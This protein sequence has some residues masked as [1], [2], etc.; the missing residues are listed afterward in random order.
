MNQQSDYDVPNKTWRECCEAACEYLNPCG[1]V[2]ATTGRTIET[3]NMEF[4]MINK[5]LHPNPIVRSGKCPQPS[6]FEHFPESKDAI[7]RFANGNLADLTT[8]LLRDFIITKLLPGLLKS[9]AIHDER[10]ELLDFYKSKPP[11]TTTVWRWM[12]RLGYKYCA[13]KKSFYVDGHERA[14]QRF[15]RKEFTEEYLLRL[16]PYCHRWL[17]VSKDELDL[18]I[19]DLDINFDP[20]Y[21]VCGYH[22]ENENGEDYVEFHVDTNDFVH[23]EASR[24]YVFGG[25]TSIRV[26]DEEFRPIIIFGQD[27]SAFHQFLL[28]SKNWT[29]PKGECALLPKSEGM[30]VMVSAIISRDTGFGLQLDSTKLAEI[31]YSRQGKKY[32]DEVAALDVRNCIDKKE[33]EESPFV[34]YFELGANNEGYWGYNHMVLQLE[35]CVDCLKVVYP[36]LDFVFLF[37]HSSGHSKKRRGGLDAGQMNSGFGGGQPTMRKSRIEHIDGYLGPYDSI[38]SAG[39]EQIMSFFPTDIGPFWMTATEQNVRRLDRARSDGV[40][41][42]PRNK[43]KKDLAAELSVPGLVL[44]PSKFRLEKLQEMAS[45][46]NIPL[47]K[48]I[49][50]IEAGWVGKQKGLLQVLWE[51]GWID[52]SRLDDYA[53]MKKDETGAVDEEFSLHCLMESCLDFANET[54]ELQSM[55]E[56]M[57]VRVISTT[58][59]HAEMAGEGIEYLWGVA[60]SWYRSKPLH[61]KS[62]KASFLELVRGC[63]DPNLITKEKVRSFSKRA[64]SYICAYYAFEHTKQNNNDNNETINHDAITLVACEIKYKTQCSVLTVVLLT[65][66]GNS[67]MPM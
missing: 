2:A 49:P 58:K 20:Q 45:A 4:R 56:K 11:S 62:K 32:T 57:G 36:H 7:K 42:K 30:A 37:D 27:E 35:D 66:I 19:D 55:G 46:Q 22:Y 6:L 9:I 51:R 1:N 60:K 41:P 29:G 13:R 8:E 3:W 24:R 10:K 48:I 54:T 26:K 53:I 28:K 52:D 38:L 5:F 34:K 33:I 64:R 18:W 50:N 31:N 40:A 63:L 16:E 47:Q 25:T 44:D 12:R 15:H 59:F 21:C 14:E 23:Q 67:V 61:L 39:V 65:W 43:T 17:Q